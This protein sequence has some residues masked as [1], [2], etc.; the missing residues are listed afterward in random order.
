MFD[1]RTKNNALSAYM[2]VWVCATF[3]FVKNNEYIDNDFVKSHTKTA[4]LLQLF[5]VATWF[6]FLH[7]SILSGFVFLNYGLNEIISI[8]FFLFTFAFMLYWMYKASKWEY[9]TIKDFGS[10]TKTENLV[11][12][13]ENVEMNEKEKMTLILAHIPF[14]GFLVYWKYY[15][16]RNKLLDNI[17]KLNAYSSFAIILIYI[18]GYSNIA[19][20]FVLF[21][22]L[23][24]V[25]SSI[26]IVMKWNILNLNLKYLKD[27]MSYFVLF[28]SFFIYLKRYFTDFQKFSV[29]ELETRLKEEQRAKDNI[30]ILSSKNDTKIPSFL[31]Y[32]PVL[33]IIFCFIKNSKYINHIKNG[34]AITSLFILILL[35]NYFYLVSLNWL[36]LLLFPIFFGI[37]YLNRLD[38]RLAFLNDAYEILESAIFFILELLHI[39]KSKH[40]EKN[41]TSF[42]VSDY[43]ECQ[44][45]EEI[46]EE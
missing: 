20:V 5:L 12:V 26:Q 36:L 32:I 39:A 1:T 23:F 33:N 30:A 8:I 17:I 43:K 24:V 27:T 31:I 28:K 22:I 37:A 9:F 4:L 45:Q 11:E 3:L 16:Y 21:Y 41:E 14:I 7:L 2:L 46:E 34:L 42:K 13:A 44:K 25:F 10:M 38:Y 6:L 18:L 40:N 15:N 19:S 29:I 35:L